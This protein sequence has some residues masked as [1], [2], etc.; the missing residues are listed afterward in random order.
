[1]VDIEDFT[2]C[3]IQF[4]DDTTKLSLG[5]AA[6]TPLKRFLKKSAFDFHQYEIAKT[7]VLV[8]QNSSPSRIWGYITLMNSEVVLNEGQRPQETSATS[9]YEA[10]P[11]VKI[12]RLAVDKALRGNG[13]GTMFL[14][15][16]MNHVKLAIMPYVGCRFLVVDAKRD[17]VAFYQKS[18]FILLNT[19]SN[20]TD[21]HPLMFFDLYRENGLPVG[22]V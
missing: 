10:F 12:A 7:Y 15:W 18:G 8:N 6:H 13:F 2:L 20:A 14:D 9:R 4:N 16:C 5:D 3:Q 19:D 22:I 21:E 11:A 17:S 1:M